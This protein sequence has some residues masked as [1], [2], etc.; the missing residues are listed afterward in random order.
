MSQ[1]QPKQSTPRSN[2]A[3]PEHTAAPQLTVEQM[4]FATVV[5][6]LLAARWAETHS[7]AHEQPSAR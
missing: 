3:Q 7:Q 2:S 1:N 6:A 5:G 4:N